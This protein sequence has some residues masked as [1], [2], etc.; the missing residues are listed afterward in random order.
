MLFYFLTDAPYPFGQLLA[1]APTPMVG[2][3]T[4]NDR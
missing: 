3:A 1:M 4:E 2:H